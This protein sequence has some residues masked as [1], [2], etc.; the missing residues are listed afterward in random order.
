MHLL[1]GGS[2]ESSTIKKEVSCKG[3]ERG[4]VGLNIEALTVTLVMLACSAQALLASNASTYVASMSAKVED[5]EWCDAMVLSPSTSGS[6]QARRRASKTRGVYQSSLRL[7]R[8]LRI[9]SQ[10][11]GSIRRNQYEDQCC[12]AHHVNFPPYR[13]RIN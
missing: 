13:L 6:K 12:P 4:G 1:M 8:A 7:G 10:Y 2:V 11:L 3:G 5:I 9:F